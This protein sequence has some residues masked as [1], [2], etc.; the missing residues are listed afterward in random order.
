MISCSAKPHILSFSP[1]HLINSTIH[2]HSCKIRYISTGDGLTAP[3]GNCSGGWYCTGGSYQAEPADTSTTSDPSAC[4]CPAVN[5]TGGQCWAGTYCPSGTNYP[6]PCDGG[7]YCGQAG[8]S[9]PEGKCDPGRS[10]LEKIVLF[11]FE[12]L[13]YQI[14][15]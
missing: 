14:S 2:E 15:S 11:C 13:T 4:S 9:A 10:A 12:L 5:Y 8:L 3:S 6:I 1:T 7:W